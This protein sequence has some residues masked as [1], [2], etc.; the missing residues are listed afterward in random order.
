MQEA[1]FFLADGII[2]GCAFFYLI[3]DFFKDSLM[4]NVWAGVGFVLV[5]FMYSSIA[6]WANVD[7]PSMLLAGIIILGP[8]V[9]VLLV[10][11]VHFLR[12]NQKR[13]IVRS[14]LLKFF[15]IIIFVYIIALVALWIPCFVHELFSS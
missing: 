10:L 5:G 4:G 2:L 1:I 15:S 11:L 9:I 14:K 13:K 3:K 6:S 7:S 12:V 8:I